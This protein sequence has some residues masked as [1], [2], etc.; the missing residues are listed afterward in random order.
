[1]EVRFAGL[2]VESAGN[3]ESVDLGDMGSTDAG[4]VDKQPHWRDMCPLQERKGA[5]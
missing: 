1:M 5:R 4:W 2:A 3:V